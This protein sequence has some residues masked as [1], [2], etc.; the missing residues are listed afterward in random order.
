MGAAGVGESFPAGRFLVGWRPKSADARV[1]SVRIRCLNPVRELRRRGYPVELFDERRAERYSVVIYSKLYDESIQAEAR[2][3][4][5]GGTKIVLDLCDNHF[6]NPRGLELLRTAATQLRGMLALA[7][8]AVASTEAMAEVIRCEGRADLPVTVIG[9]AVET[10]I[11]G[12]RTWPWDGWLARRRLRSLG[13]RLDAHPDRARIVWFG[14]H[15]GPSGDYGLGDLQV[16]RPVLE[17]LQ[18]DHPLSLTVVSNSAGR[19]ARLIRPWSI[20]TYYLE[21]HQ[22]TFLDALG[23]HGIAV[24]PV[25]ETPF[26]RCK[27]NNRLVTALAAGLAVTATGIPSYRPFAH[28]C[29]L[30]DWAGGL[31]RYI[32]DPA[33]RRSDVAA[34][35]AL[36]EREWS[37]THV[38]DQW[39][40][41]FE[42]F[43]CPTPTR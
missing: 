30:D 21:W 5:A 19:F 9:D 33:A 11:E 39:Q 40:D 37:L 27:S 41:Y 4:R 29:I 36:V 25:R 38:A 14:S 7:D 42:S 23:L 12:V 16:V 31:R 22:A 26:T 10:R 20:P 13:A 35:R 15:G 34:G 28:C 43:R 18:Q 32:L 17:S 2:R 8:A 6:Y 24:I 3:L 1:A